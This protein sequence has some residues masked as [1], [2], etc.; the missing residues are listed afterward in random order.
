MSIINKIIRIVIK[1]AYLRMMYISQKPNAKILIYTGICI[2][3]ELLLWFFHLKT[4]YCLTNTLKI[5]RKF[6]I[7]WIFSKKLSAELFTFKVNSILL[8]SNFLQ[9][10]RL[11][12]Q[13]HL[14]CT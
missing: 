5:T 6:L 11:T 8:T 2:Q 4:H 12:L 13:H 7:T 14:N 9:N 10:Q 1:Y 3:T